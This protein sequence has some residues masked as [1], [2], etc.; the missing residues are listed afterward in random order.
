MFIINLSINQ[1][2]LSISLRVDIQ[3]PYNFYCDGLEIL[4]YKGLSLKFAQ[5]KIII[6]VMDYK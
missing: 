3:E 6:K 5:Y 2:I 1:V 4:T